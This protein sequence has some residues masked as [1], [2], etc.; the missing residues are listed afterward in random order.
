[1]TAGGRAEARVE[2]ASG[3]QTVVMIVAALGRAPFT[4]DESERPEKAEDA[5]SPLRSPPGAEKKE[6]GQLTSCIEERK[7]TVY[8]LVAKLC[9]TLELDREAHERVGRPAFSRSNY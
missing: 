7:V 5:P 1:M 2:R 3:C 4:A 8:K 9:S 6:S